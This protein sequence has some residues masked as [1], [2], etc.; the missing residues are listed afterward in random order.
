MAAH[1]LLGCL[2]A[3]FVASD[4]GPAVSVPVHVDQFYFASP[5]TG[6]E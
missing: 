4:L 6:S 3:W 2:L 1:W 5:A